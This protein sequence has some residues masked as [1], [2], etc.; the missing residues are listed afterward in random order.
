[1]RRFVLALAAAFVGRRRRVSP[2][3]R[4]DRAGVRRS[5][6]R[7][8][9][10]PLPPRADGKPP[11]FAFGAY[12]RGNF[13]FALQEAERRLDENPRDA[14]AMTLIG[15]IYRDGAAEGKNDLEAS[16][17]FRLASNLGDPQA[18]Y[19][20]G[21][22]LLEGAEGRAEGP[23]RRQGAVRARRGPEPA[24]RPLQSRR[25]GARLVERPEAGLSPRRRNI[26]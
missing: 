15:V 9:R 4:P 18:A 8:F 20:L 7:R 1:M 14:A 23:G 6:G 10:R 22:L 21:A 16:R 25:H 12:Q 3:G 5:L 24:G 19:E 26:S 2:D 11:D 13:L 17:W